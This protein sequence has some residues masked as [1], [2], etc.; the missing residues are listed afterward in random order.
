MAI[1]TGHSQGLPS[2]VPHIDMLEVACNADVLAFIS[3]EGQ[4]PFEDLSIEIV[5]DPARDAR[6]VV[7]ACQGCER[8]W[9]LTVTNAALLNRNIQEPA[10]LYVFRLL[11]KFLMGVARTLCYKLS[12]VAEL[13]EWLTKRV[14][15]AGEKGVKYSALVAEAVDE[16]YCAAHDVDVMLERLDFDRDWGSTSAPGV[17]TYDDLMVDMTRIAG[18]IVN[19]PWILLPQGHPQ[20]KGW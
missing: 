7:V 20:R 15:E 16:H 11:H 19:D 10:S 18:R 9:D 8:V 12:L 14:A 5:N 2:L 4:H 6:R 1:S 3:A 13:A 17:L